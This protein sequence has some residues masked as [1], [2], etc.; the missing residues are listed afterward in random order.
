EKLSIFFTLEPI[1]ISMKTWNR[2]TPEQQKMFAD[3]GRSLEA[4]AL[5]AA[6]KEDGRVA[7]L[8]RS[9]NVKVEQL[10]P[11]AWQQWQKLFQESSFEKFRKDVPNGSQLLDETLS[12]YK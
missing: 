3:V 8:F 4:P 12:F 10:T 5:E 9:H 11:E 7:D 1:V 2:L 6:R